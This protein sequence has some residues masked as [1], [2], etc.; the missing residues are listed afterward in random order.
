MKEKTLS[1]KEMEA[2]EEAIREVKEAQGAVQLAL[3][4]EKLARISKLLG[5]VQV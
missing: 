1:A 4:D 2:L 5:V 3:L